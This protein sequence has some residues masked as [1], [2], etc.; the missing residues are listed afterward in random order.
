[1]SR[2]L[3][4]FGTTDGH[5]AKVARIFGEQLRFCGDDVEVVDAAERF[6]NPAEYDAVAVAASVHA[7]GYQRAIVRW[8]DRNHEALNRKPTIFLSVCLGI[9]QPDPAVHRDLTRIVNDFLESTSWRPVETRFVAGAL[10][11]TQYNIFKRWLMKR[12]VRK[13]HGDIDTSRDYEYTDWAGLREF[14]NGFSHRLSPSS[15]G[16][17]A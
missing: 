1:M 4:I 15:I 11:Y 12:I 8:T 13:A 5:T 9:L 6:P 3:V 10:K 14:A 16:K 17:T 2:I 7:G